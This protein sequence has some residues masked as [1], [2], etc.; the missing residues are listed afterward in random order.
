[1]TYE[2]KPLCLMSF[3]IG[4]K[5]LSYCMISQSENDREVVINDWKILDISR[6]ES[7]VIVELQICGKN[8]RYEKSD[9]FYC[10]MHAKLRKITDNLII[11]C[12]EIEKRNLNKLKKTELF[13]LGIKYNVFTEENRS[14]NK[15]S[16]MEKI[17]AFFLVKCFIPIKS[18]KNV[19]ASDINLITLG[20]NMKSLLDK[21][22]HLD[23][24]THIILENQ[25]STIA[26]RMK[27]IQ[28]MLAQYFIMKLDKDIEIKFVSSSNKLKAFPQRIDSE[29][30]KNN[31]KQ[32]KQDAIFYTKEILQKN[33]NLSSW[34]KL[35][36]DSKKRDDLSD[37]F[38]QGIWYLNHIKYLT[39]N[40]TFL[41]KKN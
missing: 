18:I 22:P 27:T 21:I 25:I 16:L 2:V 9:N 32:H 30:N 31:Y 10:E 23:K 11:P 13:D 29:E 3:D 41:L 26:S 38:L 8:A 36:C 39:I 40:D 7:S 6:D 28:G 14:E 37:S 4:I 17:D 35:F 34:L 1:M 12:K 5:N 20:R 24:V 15:K 19:N 33:K